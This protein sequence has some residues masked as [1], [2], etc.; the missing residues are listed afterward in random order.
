MTQI[1]QKFHGSLPNTVCI[2][3]LQLNGR[4]TR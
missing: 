2:I 1:K 4:T 3:G